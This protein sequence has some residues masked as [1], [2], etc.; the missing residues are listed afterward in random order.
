[1]FGPEAGSAILAASVVG[2]LVTGGN[3]VRFALLALLTDLIEPEHIYP[4]VSVAV[5]TFLES[6][7]ELAGKSSE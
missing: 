1:M 7:G 4:T 2:A 6:K 5:Q 3:P